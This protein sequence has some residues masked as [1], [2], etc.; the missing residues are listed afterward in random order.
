MSQAA[1]AHLPALPSPVTTS[2][3]LDTE[4]PESLL[5]ELGI[6][7]QAV[8]LFIIWICDFSP[9]LNFLTSHMESMM[10]LSAPKQHFNNRPACHSLCLLSR[11]CSFLSTR[12]SALQRS[13]AS[14]LGRSSGRKTYPHPRVHSRTH[15][16]TMLTPPL[17]SALLWTYPGTPS[18][19]CPVR[20]V[21]DGGSHILSKNI[22][23]PDNQFPAIYSFA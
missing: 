23:S 10:S 1:C 6:F 18:L 21:N 15:T 16:S 20:H 3:R 13:P 17:P 9:K 19:T 12:P 11:S 8:L 7:R 5:K 22:T 14:V 4:T 2:G